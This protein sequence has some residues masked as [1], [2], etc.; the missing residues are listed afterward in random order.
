MENAG[1]SMPIIDLGQLSS[2]LF[3]PQVA[4]AR[5]FYLHRTGT[6]ASEKSRGAV[7]SRAGRRSSSTKGGAMGMVVGGGLEVVS[8]RY[9]IE[10]SGLEFIGIEL[11]VGGTGR[12]VLAG[13]SHVLR[14]GSCFTYGPRIPH[15]IETDPDRPLVKYFVDLTPA[16]GNKLLRDIGINLG[17]AW[18]TLRAPEVASLWDELVREGQLAAGESGRICDRLVEAILLRSAS[19][20]VSPSSGGIATAG[21]STYRRCIRIL[22]D[23]ALELRTLT[24]LARA[25]GIRREYLCRL[26]KRFDDRPP[27]QRLL[28]ARMN[29]AAARLR[30]P[31][32]LVKQVAADLGYTDPFHFS[33][34]FRRTFGLSPE[35]F[36]SK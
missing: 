23:R 29:I 19:S 17:T 20:R 9:R 24:Q 33:R 8:P 34:V 12:L 15:L 30:E 14:P 27:Y 18:E 4:E 36:R 32:M 11:V 10:R 13:Q 6:L 1:H 2:G 21:F 22:E 31:E 35:R 5:R 26:F 28:R 16:A 25:C 3:S 7:K